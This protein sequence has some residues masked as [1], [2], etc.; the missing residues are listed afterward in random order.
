MISTEF[1]SLAAHNRWLG[2]T[3]AITE[4]ELVTRIGLDSA[5]FLRFLKSQLFSFALITVFLRGA[6][7]A[8]LRHRL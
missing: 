2:P 4:D 7:L 5:K 6:D 3:L 1:S 8:R